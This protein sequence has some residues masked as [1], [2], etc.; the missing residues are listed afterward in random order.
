MP[1]APRD[2]VALTVDVEYRPAPDPLDRSRSKLISGSDQFLRHL[3]IL[4]LAA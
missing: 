2:G 4:Q 3:M 1:A